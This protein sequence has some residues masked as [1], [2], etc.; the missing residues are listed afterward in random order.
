[1]KFFVT[2][3]L[4]LLLT[5]ALSAATA[6]GPE[7]VVELLNEIPIPGDA[8]RNHLL[9]VYSRVTRSD[10]TP[11]FMHWYKS[12]SRYSLLDMEIVPLKLSTGISTGAP[13]YIFAKRMVM[14]GGGDSVFSFPP[15]GVD[16]FILNFDLQ[17]G[18]LA[19]PLNEWDSVIAIADASIHESVALRYVVDTG[20]LSAILELLRHRFRDVR[21]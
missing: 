7:K 12:Q 6:I 3:C 15:R 9:G 20:D 4:S 1:M 13:T 14:V 5:S 19:L 17:D 8:A 10:Y 11:E 18:I 21:P 16:T 2:S